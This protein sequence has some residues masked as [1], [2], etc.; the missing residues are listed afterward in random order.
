MIETDK[1]RWIEKERKRWAER[2]RIPF[3]EEGLPEGFPN[4]TLEVCASGFNW[5]LLLLLLLLLLLY[6]CALYERDVQ[7]EKLSRLL[8]SM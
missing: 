3:A 5:F 4:R 8:F 7:V 2:F 6:I 1:D